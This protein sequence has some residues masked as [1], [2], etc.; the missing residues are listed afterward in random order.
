MIKEIPRPYQ[1]AELYMELQG[2]DVRL[3]IMKTRDF[4]QTLGDA[5]L[6]LTYA[7]KREHEIGDERLLNIISRTHIRHAL[8]DYNGCFDLLLQIPWFLFRLWKVKGV[9]RNKRNW[10]IRAENVCN[11]EDVVNQLKQFQEDNVKNFLN[12]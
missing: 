11:Y 8:I 2:F 1:E 12:D 5:Q 6:S 3:A 9:R 7:D 10:V 4:L